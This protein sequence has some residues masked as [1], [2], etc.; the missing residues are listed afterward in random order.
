ME[1][2]KIIKLFPKTDNYKELLYDKEGMYSIT[3][4]KEAN[5]ISSLISLHF[6]SS[7]N[8]NILDGTA[9]LGGNTFSFSKYFNNVTSIELDK[10]RF[11]ML[12]KNVLIYELKNVKL[13]ND[14][15]INYIKNNNDYDIFFFDPPWGGPEYRNNK[16][17]RF[18]LD[19]YNLVDI[20]NLIKSKEKIIVFKLPFNYDF[21]EFSSFNYK[22]YKIRNY[23][24][25]II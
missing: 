7:K 22:L 25:I 11:E 13:I 6:E 20:I 1:N 17:I 18:K 10:N 16:N 12:K 21:S 2:H 3:Y 4:P 5:L 9:G 24:V 14:S 19:S 15:S 23:N 8:L